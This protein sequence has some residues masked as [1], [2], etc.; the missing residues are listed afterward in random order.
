VRR[1]RRL[2][3]SFWYGS[4][5]FSCRRFFLNKLVMDISNFVVAVDDSGWN[6][7]IFG[8]PIRLNV[9]L[10]NK[11]IFSVLGSSSV[12]GLGVQVLLEAVECF[13]GFDGDEFIDWTKFKS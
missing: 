7:P 13:G 11:D 12:V 10:R 1:A 5:L 2:R 9:H 8:F 4:R 3:A 6:I